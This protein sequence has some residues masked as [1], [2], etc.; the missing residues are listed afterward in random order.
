MG[1]SLK[2]RVEFPTL[3]GKLIGFPVHQVGHSVSIV[4]SAVMVISLQG[5]TG[6]VG[7]LC[8]HTAV[9]TVQR[10]AGVAALLA[11]PSPG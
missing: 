8:G 11:T 7:L 1:R 4:H 2:G 6:T 10:G 5:L 3:S 9:F